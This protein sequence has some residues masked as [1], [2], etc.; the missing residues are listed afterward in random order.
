MSGAAWISVFRRIILPLLMPS[1]VAGW[2]WVA[3]HSGREL[4]V[5]LLLQSSSNRIISAYV[6]QQ[7]FGGRLNLAAAAGVL[8][9]LLIIILVVLTRLAGQRLSRQ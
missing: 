9:V 7:F 1:L 2:L 3:I 8:L 5:A 6:W 4:T